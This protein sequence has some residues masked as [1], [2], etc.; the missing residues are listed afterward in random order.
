MANKQL[1]KTVK[2]DLT[3]VPERCDELFESILEQTLKEAGFNLEDYDEEY[4][5][6]GDALQS[7]CIDS[8]VFK[9]Y[10]IEE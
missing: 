7:Y 5:D 1:P 10:S 3:L 6:Y 9:Q 4:S 2:L 8:I